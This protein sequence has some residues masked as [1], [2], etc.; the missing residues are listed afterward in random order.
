M[1]RVPPSAVAAR[2]A[3]ASSRPARVSDL[4]GGPPVAV[5]VKLA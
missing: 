1:Y 2:I 5:K 4:R 3:T